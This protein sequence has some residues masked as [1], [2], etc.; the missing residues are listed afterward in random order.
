MI[1]CGS[2][3]YQVVLVLCC[4]IAIG[5]MPIGMSDDLLLFVDLNYC[6][7]LLLYMSI[8]VFIYHCLRLLLPTSMITACRRWSSC[9]TRKRLK[10]RHSFKRPTQRWISSRSNSS[11]GRDN[12]TPR[13]HKVT[14]LGLQATS[15]YSMLYGILT[16]GRDSST[17]LAHMVTSLGPQAICIFSMLY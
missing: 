17:P 7:Y 5:V 9:S 10:A 3:A 4:G 8:T 6:L 14:S 11:T 2:V 16:A 13:P 15:I 12:S 1:L